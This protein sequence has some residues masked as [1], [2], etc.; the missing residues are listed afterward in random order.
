M[1]PDD[2]DCTQISRLT[3]LN[4][5]IYMETLYVDLRAIMGLVLV[6]LVALHGCKGINSVDSDLFKL[7]RESSIDSLFMYY[8]SDDEIF[9]DP[10]LE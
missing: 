5:G 2:E 6:E 8:V 4:I 10:E 3:L 7:S 9:I 1:D